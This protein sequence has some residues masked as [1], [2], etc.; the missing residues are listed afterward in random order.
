MEYFK[1]LSAD[2]FMEHANSKQKYNSCKIKGLKVL[3]SLR[4]I[5]IMHP[6]K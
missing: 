3:N 2:V 1:S 5:E 4:A 6:M